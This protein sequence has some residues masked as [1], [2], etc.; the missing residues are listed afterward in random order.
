MRFN[1]IFILFLFC[2]SYVTYADHIR[3]CRVTLSKMSGKLP[4]KLLGFEVG[5]FY[6][7][8]MQRVNDKG[9]LTHAVSYASPDLTPD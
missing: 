1:K 6:H 7:V 5:K 2:F 3:V 8:G 4:T 9:S